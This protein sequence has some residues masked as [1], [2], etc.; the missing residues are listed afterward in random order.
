MK[1]LSSPR[2]IRASQAGMTLIEMLMVIGIGSLIVVG[3]FTLFGNTSEKNK[4][5]QMVRDYGT[6]KTAVNNVYAQ[7]PNYQGINVATI[8]QSGAIPRNMLTGAAR[9]G[10]SSVY[11]AVTLAPAGGN[12][13][14]AA[15]FTG[16]NMPKA[17]CSSFV[18][19]IIKSVRQIDI[20][21]TTL[22]SASTPANINAACGLTAAGDLLGQNIVVTND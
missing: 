5:T 22:T 3:G 13:Q 16:T 10:I 14:W 6:I 21:G 9:N 8:A 11:G 19:S 2:G 15:T 20:N 17:V 7:Q 12:M 4:A 1:K 18:S